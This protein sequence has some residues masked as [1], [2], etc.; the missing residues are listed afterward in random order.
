M[1][2]VLDPSG[3]VDA[4]LYRELGQGQLFSYN[5]ASEQVFK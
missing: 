5:V 1:D 4:T 3:S 2:R